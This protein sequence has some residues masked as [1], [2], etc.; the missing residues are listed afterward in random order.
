MESRNG[1]GGRETEVPCSDTAGEAFQLEISTRGK[2]ED[3]RVT[4]NKYNL[5]HPQAIAE[6]S[7]RTC[8][9]TGGSLLQGVK[10]HCS[11]AESEMRY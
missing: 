3:F 4:Y 7:H 5:N 1:I 11:G 2:K 6:T 9:A 8:G 10:P